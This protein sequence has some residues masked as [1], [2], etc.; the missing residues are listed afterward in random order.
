MLI[1]T[2]LRIFAVL[3]L[4]AILVLACSSGGTSSVEQDAAPFDAGPSVAKREVRFCVFAK[5]ALR[6][7]RPAMMRGPRLKCV[8]AGSVV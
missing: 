6:A 7:R 4:A 2:K 3:S 8:F 1:M 5:A